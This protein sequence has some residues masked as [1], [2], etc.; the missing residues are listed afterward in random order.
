MIQFNRPTL[1]IAAVLFA[2]ALVGGVSALAVA[3][4]EH[5]HSD[6][7]DK[8]HAEPMKAE[9][10]KPAPDF[11]LTD[12]NGEEHTLST[13]VEEGYTVVLEWFN[14][15][16]PFVKKHHVKFGTMAATYETFQ[17]E[18]VVW[19][20]VN[21]GGKGKQGAGLERNQ[22]AIEDYEI[23]YPVL[24]DETGDVGKMYGAKTTPQM[25]VISEGVLVFDGPLDDKASTSELGEMNYIKD[26]VEKCCAGKEVDPTKVK[27]YG[28][29]VKYAS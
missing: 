24:L 1:Q 17:E 23:A 7:A 14:P 19:L 4:D 13:Y 2:V 29:S 9:V 11:T 25:Y 27:S 5:D 20:A 26:V 10:G 21:S 18:K 3:G 8:D 6:H 12:T 15:D 22:K 28:C 16:C